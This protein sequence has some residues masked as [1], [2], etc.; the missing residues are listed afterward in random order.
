MIKKY[1]FVICSK[2]NI[3]I[4]TFLFFCLSLQDFYLYVF[5]FAYISVF[6]AIFF[7]FYNYKELQL[8]SN[9]KSLY[10]IIFILLYVSF[11]SI[12]SN[13]Y[14]YIDLFQF[15]LIFFLILIF[16]SKIR[17]ENFYFIVKILEY[18]IFFH[19]FFFYLQFFYWIFFEQLIDFVAFFGDTQSSNYSNKGL[20]INNVRLIR[21]S[22]LFA[23]PGTY[24][25]LIMSMVAVLSF[26]R[27]NLFIILPACISVIL[28]SATLGILLFL[29]YIMY[30]FYIGSIYFNFFLIIFISILI[31]FFDISS[32]F[33]IHA[34]RIF[35]NENLSNDIDTVQSR[36]DVL[37]S[38]WMPEN[39]LLGVKIENLRLAAEDNS[40]FVTSFINGGLFLFLMFIILFLTLFF[41]NKKEIIFIILIVFLSK[42]KWSY[43]MFWILILIMLNYNKLL[44]QN[45][46]KK[47]K[48]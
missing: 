44:R 46:D 30:L 34:E 41:N 16:Y 25:S 47:I 32:Y 1:P 6:A 17:N 3:F 28:S 26:L 2:T 48:S 40:S 29:I 37:K 14:F 24:A 31:L 4:S 22:G 12:K 5:G 38:Y 8:K 39:F 36:F 27:L 21:P 15:F 11:K 20:I 13:D 43:F 9:L 19:F 10:L 42:I 18:S 7:I 33:Y 45:V 35:F 23:E